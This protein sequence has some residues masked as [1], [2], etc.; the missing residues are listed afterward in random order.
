MMII[1]IVLALLLGL[2]LSAF[3]GLALYVAYKMGNHQDEPEED[4][5]A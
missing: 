5:E 3:T 2:F 1:L 4:I